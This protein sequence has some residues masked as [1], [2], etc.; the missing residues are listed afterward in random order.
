M[1]GGRCRRRSDSGQICGNTSLTL[2]RLSLPSH[3][4]KSVYSKSLDI[5]EA[6]TKRSKE[7]RYSLPLS[8]SS[9]P[10][11]RGSERCSGAFCP[12]PKVQRSHQFLARTLKSLTLL[13]NLIFRLTKAAFTIQELDA[14]APPL[15]AL[16]QLSFLFII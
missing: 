12:K 7:E 13:I 3:C 14:P 2:C 11:S 15:L 8:P 4:S 10:P 1:W 5:P 6:R 16:A 9:S